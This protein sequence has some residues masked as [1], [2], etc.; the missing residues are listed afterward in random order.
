MFQNTF[1]SKNK[2]Y[3][4]LLPITNFVDVLDLLYAHFTHHFVILCQGL[5]ISLQNVV[6][7]CAVA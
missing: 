1:S 4:Q 5:G 7:T 2:K 3:L 6:F